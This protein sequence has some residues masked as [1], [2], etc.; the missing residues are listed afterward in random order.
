MTFVVEHHEAL[1][2]DLL[3]Q[4]FDLLDFWRGTLTPRRLRILIASLPEKSR[5]VAELDPER[6]LAAAWDTVDYLLAAQYNAFLQA[7]FEGADPILPPVEAYR[8]QQEKQA[9]EQRMVD[10][11]AAQRER[12]RQRDRA[13]GITS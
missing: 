4:G 6:A 9:A 1:E 10:M 2:I 8:Q 12:N 5:T 3:G 7:N 11:L 13:A